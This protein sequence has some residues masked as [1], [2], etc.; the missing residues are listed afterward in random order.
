MLD[1]LLVEEVNFVFLFFEFGFFEDVVVDVR[2][3]EEMFF[4]NDFVINEVS[5]EMLVFILEVF[6]LWEKFLL[7]EEWIFLVFGIFELFFLFLDVFSFDCWDKIVWLFLVY[8]VFDFLVLVDFL[9]WFKEWLVIFGLSV[10]IYC[11]GGCC[12]L[13]WEWCDG[14]FLFFGELLLIVDFLFEVL[15]NWF[16]CGWLGYFFCELG[17]F[18]CVYFDNFVF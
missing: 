18:L 7:C 3:E 6:R 10:F 5:F 16:W 8:F 9:L 4:F 14:F 17:F 15:F 2:E 12:D 13:V 1:D 11:E